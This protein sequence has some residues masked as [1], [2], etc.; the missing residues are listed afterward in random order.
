EPSRGPAREPPLLRRHDPGRGGERAPGLGPHVASLLGLRPGLAAPGNPHVP[1]TPRRDLNQKKRGSVSGFVT[2]FRIEG[3]HG[4]GPGQGDTSTVNELDI[5]SAALELQSPE[6]RARYLD[7]ACGDNRELRRR[8]EALLASHAQA[9][10]F[11][12]APAPALSPLSPAGARGAGK[13]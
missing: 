2:Q 11:M 8:I 9:A 5:F 4:T 12:N 3:C 13:E 6:E 1:A 7:R 10:S